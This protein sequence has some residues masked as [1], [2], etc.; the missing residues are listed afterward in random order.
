MKHKYEI[1]GIKI[2]IDHHYDEY[3]KDNIEHYKIDDFHDVDYAMTVHITD[4]IHP[5]QGHS[6]SQKNPYIIKNNEEIIMYAQNAKHE[7]K[8]LFIIKNNYHHI[9]IYIN[10]SLNPNASE[11]EYVLLSII[12]MEIAMRNQFLPFHASAILYQD[13]AILFSAP[14]QTGKSTHARYWKQ[15]FQDVKFINDDKPLLKIE[16]DSIM[17]YGS[18]FSGKSSINQNIKAP[19][20]AIVFIKQGLTNVMRPIQGDEALKELMKNMLRPDDESV[21]DDMIQV[22]NAIMEDIP[23]FILEATH[24]VDAAKA[25]HDIIFGG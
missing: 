7:I 1:V 12:F 17:V 18:P 15:A 20:R 19:L 25:A 6:Y 3:L 9:E 22:I 16:D 14:S 23:M 4:D 2:S 10:Q 5:P 24:S 21:W 11:M 8:E 13:Q